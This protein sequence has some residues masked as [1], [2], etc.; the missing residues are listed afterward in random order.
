MPKSPA[1][2][3]AAEWLRSGKAPSSRKMEVALA[4]ALL[5][6]EVPLSPALLAG[7]DIGSDVMLAMVFVAES[8]KMWELVQLL[9]DHSTDKKC[10]KL[11]KK[12]LYRAKQRGHLEAKAQPERKAVDL[13]ERAEAPPSFCTSFDRAGAQV[14]LYGGTTDIDGPYGLVGIT[15]PVSGVESM[16]FVARPSRKRMKQLAE[17]IAR[18]FGGLVVEVEDHFAAGRLVAGIALADAANTVVDGDVGIGRRLLQGSTSH[19]G[20]DR[21][22]IA[23]ANAESAERLANSADL[24]TK[25]C[26]REW[27]TADQG[28]VVHAAS[29]AVP[30]LDEP[31]DDAQLAEQVTAAVLQA[32]DDVVSGDK[33]ALVAQQLQ[34]TACL[35]SRDQQREEALTAAAVGAHLAETQTPASAIP[36]IAA[37]MSIKSCIDET[38]RRAQFDQEMTAASSKRS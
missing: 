21:A 14:I 31:A 22:L 4:M 5:S 8:Q 1:T 30:P 7:C 12:V 33:R 11:A 34:I 10:A 36:F 27:F 16:S 32:V 28:T 35:L 17:D 29:S 6:G 26:F 15:N 3:D 18:R 38:V 24:A 19:D 13:S 37:A 2:R 23:E 20:Y 9:C 25:Q